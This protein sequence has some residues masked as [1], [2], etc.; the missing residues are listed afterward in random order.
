MNRVTLTRHYQACNRDKPDRSVPSKS[1]MAENGLNG[2]SLLEREQHSRAQGGAPATRENSL[3]LLRLVTL[4]AEDG[5]ESK[6]L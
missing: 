3:R 4:F 5:T 1:R 2:L 6:Q